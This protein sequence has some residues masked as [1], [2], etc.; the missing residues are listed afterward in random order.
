MST[1]ITFDSNFNV[2]EEKRLIARGTWAGSFGSNGEYYFAHW[3]YNHRY[4]KTGG[5]QK[6]FYAK[7]K[8]MMDPWSRPK[9]ITWANGQSINTADP[10]VF[11]DMETQKAWM[12]LWT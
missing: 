10:G 6:I 8:N 1:P 5:T 4:L 3:Y 2:D 9:E 12:G 7:A 11:W